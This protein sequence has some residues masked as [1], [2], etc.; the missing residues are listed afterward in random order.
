[1]Q[2]DMIQGRAMTIE[3]VFTGRQYQLDSYQR[4]YTWGRD[5]IRRLMDDLRKKFMANWSLG[6]D[7]EE[8]ASY[9]PYFLGPYVY[10]EEAHTTFLVDGQQRITTL[11]LMLIYLREL[12]RAQDLDDE[13]THLSGLIQSRKFGKAVYTLD[14]PDR[15]RFLAEVFS[16]PDYTLPD[17]AAGDLHRLWEGAR[18][19]QEEFPDELRSDALPYFVD[20]LLDGVCMVGIRAATSEQG[21]EIYESMND[22]GVRLGPIDLLKSFLLSRIGGEKGGADKIWRQMVSDLAGIDVNAPSEFIKTFLIGRYA[23]VSIEPGDAPT[24]IERING[25]FHTWAKDNAERLGL[26]RSSDFQRLITDLAE[27]SERFRTVAAAATVYD[28]ELQSIF[29]NAYNGIKAQAAPILAAVEPKDDSGTFKAKAKL[30]ADYLDLLFARRSVNDLPSSGINSYAAR[31]IERVRGGVSVDKLRTILAEEVSVLDYDFKSMKTYGLRSNNSGQVRYL[32]A[33]LTGF[34]QTGCRLSDDMAAYLDVSRPYEI[35][36][37]W[38]NHFERFQP[39]TGTRA[40]FDS[41]RNRLGA[42]LLLRKSDNASYQDLPYEK[43]VDYYQRQNQLAGALHTSHRERNPTFN[44]FAKQHKLDRLLRAF[45]KFDKKAIEERQILYQR[46]CELIWDPAVFGTLPTVATRRPDPTRTRTRAR[47]DV[48]VADLIVKG[49][50][51]SNAQLVGLRRG[52][53]FHALALADGRIQVASGEI[54]RSLSGAG[55]FVLQTKACPG[56]NFWQADV[57]GGL[58]RLID[59]RR[60]ALERGLV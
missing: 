53:R 26:H 29:F 39:E 6:H 10:H 34:V 49:L 58:V 36:H 46:L 13:A 7:R 52:E 43:K 8:V 19:L 18:V 42:L 59:I 38:A 23:D 20:W 31:L 54:F 32:L 11:H 45:A 17:N 16:E 12:L 47:Y 35:E 24:D 14:I 5:D 2:Q 3:E 33:R 60:D 51:P 41:Y 9:Q 37:I 56:W 28:S 55:E 57:D 4:D 27:Y 44:K 48:T 22:R 50:L 15:G 1:M 21:W 25:S 40:A 30:I